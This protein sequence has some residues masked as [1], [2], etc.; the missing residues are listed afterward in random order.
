V[1]EGD[2]GLVPPQVC[3]GGFDVEKIENSL[4]RYLTQVDSLRPFSYHGGAG[5]VV[6]HAEASRF[7]L[8]R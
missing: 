3:K 8:R 1:R 5:T 4:G 6:F 7:I 2:A